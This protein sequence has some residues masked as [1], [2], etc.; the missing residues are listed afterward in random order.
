LNAASTHNRTQAGSAVPR[1][2]RVLTLWDLIFYGIVLIMPIAPVPMF[3]VAQV[4]SQG[5]FVTT[6]LIAMIAMML[7]AVSYGRMATLYP[8]AGSAYTYVGR[9]LNPHLGFLT[10]WAMF[11]DYL[12]QPLLN[13]IYGALTIQRF[14]PFVPY[15]ALAAFFVGI[16]TLLNLRG[17]RATARANIALLT[18]ACTVIGVFMVVA[19]RYLFRLQGWPGVFS[20][21]PFYDPR[22][23]NLRIIWTAT[24]Y[25]A[26]TYIGF[27]GVTTLAED[28]ENPK[29]NVM[30]ATVLVCLFTGIVGGLEVYLGQRVWPNFRSFPNAE[31]AFM[32]VTRRVGGPL[33][34]QALGLVL[35]LSTV[36][37][38]LTGQ[39]GAARLLF[40]MG[41]DDVLPRKLFAYLDPKRN[42]PTR[43]IWLIGIVAYIGTLFISY[44]QAGEIL[45]FG[46]FLAFMGVNLAAFAQFAVVQQAGRK[47]RWFADVVMPLSGFVFCLWIWLGLRMPAKI[48][49]GIWF[50]GGLVYCAIKTRGFRERPIMIDFSE[51]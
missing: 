29:R 21:Q 8:T 19:V 50:M 6:I 9:G 45:N 22:T 40:G 4:L 49:G 43:N 18:I 36:G 48:V 12:I 31:T 25:A 10:G 41:R 16:M 14:F 17:I 26:L 28:V 13:G 7:T 34:F 30:L 23:F 3:G 1:L 32:D 42:T 24:S 27:D 38:G 5:H 15:A 2:R 35:I 11:L 51:S 47:R 33:L 39:V 20:V 44:E 37:A 46:A